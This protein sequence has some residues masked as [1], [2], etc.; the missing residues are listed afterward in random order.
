MAAAATPSITFLP[1][2]LGN[3][4]FDTSDAAGEKAVKEFGGTF[5]EVGPDAAPRTRRCRSSTPPPSRA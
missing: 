2:N 4:Y 1:K 3:P 5:D